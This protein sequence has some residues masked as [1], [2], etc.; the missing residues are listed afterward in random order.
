MHNFNC[1]FVDVWNNF[2]NNS[3]FQIQPNPS[4]EY[5]S[6]TGIDQKLNYKICN[7]L[8]ET[9]KVGEYLPGSKINTDNLLSGFYILILDNYPAKRFF[10]K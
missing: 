3:N 4:E 6:V 9:V 2:P 1:K 10:K 7:Q 5:I 8:G